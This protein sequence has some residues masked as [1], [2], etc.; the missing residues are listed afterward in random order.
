MAA[1]I[2]EAVGT[3]GSPTSQ[4]VARP[5]NR[6]PLLVV[7]SVTQSSGLPATGL[8]AQEMQIQ[9]IIVAA[10]GSLVTISTVSEQKPGTYLLD[11]VP[12]S[13]SGTWEVGRYL[14]WLAVKSGTDQGQT[15]FAVF[16]D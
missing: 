1:L 8:T 9:A 11:V 14:F 7:A 4:G 3:G 15:V 16:V 2:V 10:G 5:G 6:D 13:V 12:A